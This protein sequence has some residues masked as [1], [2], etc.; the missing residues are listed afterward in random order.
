MIYVFLL[1]G[2]F[3]GWSFGRNNLSNVF[4][5][6]IGTRMVSF[7]WSAFLAG[8]FILLGAMLSSSSTTDSM[9]ALGQVDSAFG[10]FLMS[11]AI[12]T[13]IMLA[14]YFGIPVSIVQSSAA[15]IVGWNLFYAIPNAWSEIM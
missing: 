10:A 2:L 9:L 3:L 11:V 15:A 4:G 8:V 13:T 1:G 6:A 14:G 12:G 5:T 7:R